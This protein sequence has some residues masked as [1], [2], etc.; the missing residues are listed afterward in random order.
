MRTLFLLMLLT[1]D[2]EAA[3]SIK[4]FTD[5]PN[6][7]NPSNSY[8][9]PMDT[10]DHALGG[11]PYN[12]ITLSQFASW[13]GAHGITNV[14]ITTSNFTVISPGGFTNLNLTPNSLMKSDVNDA[15]T[16]VANGTGALTNNGSGA[17]GWVPL[18]FMANNSG[19]G[20]NI[21]LW[22][23]TIFDELDVDNAILTNLF[24]LITNAPLLSTDGNGKVTN[25]YPLSA[26]NILLSPGA[27]ITFTTNSGT[28]TVAAAGTLSSQVYA[29]NVVSGGLL[30]PSVE[31]LIR[32]TNN[33]ANSTNFAL[34]IGSNDTNQTWLIGSNGT[35][36]D[37][38]LSSA[39]TNEVTRQI[40][41]GTNIY[42]SLGTAISDLS[43]G[44]NNNFAV[45][46]NNGGGNALVAGSPGTGLTCILTNITAN[47]TLAAMTFWTAGMSVI[48]VYAS[49]S[50]GTDRTLKF[51][52]NFQG[53]G[54]LYGID[55][56]GTGVTITNAEASWFEV[57]C[58]YGVK[59]NVFRS[60][61]K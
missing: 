20:T 53:S 60:N 50:G 35:N 58:I 19:S 55:L 45:K 38:K 42:A 21:T 52:A 37:N 57:R 7:S 40:N 17:F 10:G 12:Y 9:L 32:A 33:D 49:C 4:Y 23:T 24:T 41:S 51:P 6:Q 22:G 61:T 18:S 46:T 1:V 29:S 47:T 8:A 56:N 27:N 26:T 43:I 30:S 39:A 2:L 25:G 48:P 31:D 11:T 44:T 59:T 16:S 13:L 34:L 36:N 5:Y 15:E 14:T 3:P 54:D 28:V